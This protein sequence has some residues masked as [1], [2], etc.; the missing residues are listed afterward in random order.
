M[1]FRANSLLQIVLV[2]TIA[3][4]LIVPAM[5]VRTSADWRMTIVQRARDDDGVRLLATRLDGANRGQ[6]VVDE[7]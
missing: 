1:P 6:H 7:L 5:N 3:A 4:G 2:V